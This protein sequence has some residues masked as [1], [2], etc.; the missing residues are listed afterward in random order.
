MND[1]NINARSDNPP[2]GARGKG[3]V[4][5]AVTPLTGNLQLDEAAVESMFGNFHEHH[6][7]PFILGTT[8]ESASLPATVKSNYLK[9]AV[10][11]RKP[12][13]VLYAG[14]SSN[15]LEESIAFAHECFDA[16][17]DAVAATLPSYYALT[18]DQMKKYFEQLADAIKAP[19]VIYNIPATTHMSIPLQVIDELSHHEHIVATKDSER[20]EERLQASWQLWKGRDDFSHFLGWAAKS[21]DALL[22][23]SG[24]IPSTGNLYP[25]VYDDMANAAANG[26]SARAHELQRLSDALGNLYQGGRLLGESL[27]ALKLLMNEV[28]LCEPYVMPPLQSLSAEEEKKIIEDWTIMVEK[29]GLNIG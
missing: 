4:I 26:D 12:N 3:V 13:S 20:S 18:E 8:G 9:A 15:C 5:P 1:E 17:V 14:I 2:S 23:G 24:L 27:R 22:N 28:G 11:Y 25:K 10:R 21:A 16:G 19:L 6:V 29:E 7:H